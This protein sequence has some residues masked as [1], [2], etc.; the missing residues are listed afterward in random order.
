MRI[1]QLVSLV[2]AL[3]LMLLQK[4]DI[5]IIQARETAVKIDF[6]LLSIK[7]IY[8]KSQKKK[9]K[10][11]TRLAKRLPILIKL[12]GYIVSKSEVTVFDTPLTAALYAPTSI[13]KSISL[14]VS[15]P[16]VYTY[17]NNTARSVS[18]INS[19]VLNDQD[20]APNLNI[21]LR[22]RLIF[23]IISPLVLLYYILKSK[24]GGIIK[25]V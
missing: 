8:S 17:L 10:K 4:I 16:V 13:L 21:S 1:V 14:L 6:S 20:S 23:V 19:P 12:T 5:R 22:F 3:I 7:L 9:L 15:R 24:I 11:I 18:Y 25:S 2:L